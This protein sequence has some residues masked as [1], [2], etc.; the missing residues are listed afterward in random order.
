MAERENPPLPPP[1]IPRQGKKADAEYL[2]RAN[3]IVD[4][5][6]TMAGLTVEDRVLDIGCGAGR[7]LTGM[8]ATFG[9]VRSYTG[10]DVRKPVIDWALEAF[11]DP[12]LGEI[13]FE[14]LD[15]TNSRYHATGSAS[16]ADQKLPVEDS[17]ADVA[18]LVSVF[19]H[20][21][22]EDT[23]SYLREISRAL[24]PGGRCYCTA[25]VE[26][27]VPDWEEN[28]ESYLRDW[29][30]PLH[31]TLFNRSVFDGLVADAGLSIQAFER[32]L[33]SEYVLT[34]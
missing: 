16:P 5:V 33:Q 12:A 28:P 9:R 2:D 18:V 10:L 17:S 20:M 23:A 8:I 7:F 13:R 11:T 32:G 29:S 31:C 4:R 26:D 27:G 19:S 14:W 3:E 30:G 25:F 24:A 1:G 22:L 34:V 6:S 21:T 15:V